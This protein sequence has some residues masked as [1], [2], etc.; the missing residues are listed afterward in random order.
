MVQYKIEYFHHLMK[1]E[2]LTFSL[3]DE[4]INILEFLEKEIECPETVAP[5][6]N[7]T[8]SYHNLS[9]HHKHS[10][11]GEHKKKS[12]M[13]GNGKKYHK[14]H[15]S[16]SG[17]ST[18]NSASASANEENWEIARNFKATVIEKKTGIDKVINDVRINLNKMSNTNYEKQKD[19]ILEIVNSY[20]TNE[21][22][23]NDEN[24]H[25]ICNA[26]F[27]IASSNKFFSELY[28]QIYETLVNKYPTFNK[29][30]D[31]LIVDF[32][33]IMN[34]I[35]YVDP[36]KDY[37]G[38]C[39]Y[40]ELNLKRQSTTTFMINLM[41]KG[42]I[43]KSVVL[44]F[45]REFLDTILKLIDEEDKSKDVEEIV[46]NLFIMYSQTYGLYSDNEYEDLLNSINS[47][48]QKLSQSFSKEYLSLSNRAIFKFM[49]M[50]ELSE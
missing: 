46:E 30:I 36:N 43:Q 6:T 4:V 45:I 13:G 38:F 2:T 37:D 11:G 23:C 21:E 9:P 15:S 39:K 1:D 31:G 41:K 42:L 35:F 25:L 29:Y 24:T 18:S 16:A 22:L 32:S 47:D 12:F 5:T 19:V 10:G 3:S 14:N 50:M 28:V 17:V 33:K 49:D 40:T 34:N 48:I 26:I 44:G 7:N 8:N 20:F 27:E